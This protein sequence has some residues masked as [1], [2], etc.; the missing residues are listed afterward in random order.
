MG[1]CYIFGLGIDKNADKGVLWLK[2]SSRNYCIDDK[3]I[4]KDIFYIGKDF[5]DGMWGLPPNDKEGMYWIRRSAAA[6][7]EKAISFIDNSG[8]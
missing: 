5:I 2:I 4:S 7:Y 6:G 3:C 8:A 1:Q